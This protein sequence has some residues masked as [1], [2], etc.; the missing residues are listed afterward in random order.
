MASSRD[1]ACANNTEH[2]RVRVVE[3]LVLA[4]K[5]DI[6]HC[7]YPQRTR[8]FKLGCLII[9]VRAADM[10]HRWKLPQFRLNFLGSTHH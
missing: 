1:T 4:V 10:L 3:L 6:L 2:G 5:R 8:N 9:V 7:Q